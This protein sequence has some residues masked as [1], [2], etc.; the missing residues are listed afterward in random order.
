MHRSLDS[1][2]TLHRDP[3]LELNFAQ[4]FTVCL[5]RARELCPQYPDP[6]LDFR[7]S[8]MSLIWSYI[9]DLTRSDSA[10]IQLVRL[11]A[12]ALLTFGTLFSPQ[13]RSSAAPGTSYH[14][15]ISSATLID[16]TVDALLADLTCFQSHGV[17]WRLRARTFKACIVRILLWI[18]RSNVVVKP[19]D[20]ERL[21]ILMSSCQLWAPLEEQVAI[22]I[23]GSFDVEEQPLTPDDLKAV[24]DFTYSVQFHTLEKDGVGGETFKGIPRSTFIVHGADV[25]INRLNAHFNGRADWRYHLYDLREHSVTCPRSV[26]REEGML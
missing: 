21:G 20:W 16:A 22:S 10:E 26:Y 25:G 19:K 2:I 17:D 9:D 23:T 4:G 12:E 5:Q 11:S 6:E 1:L 13:P 7:Y 3:T 8:L 24:K 15:L 18:W 14:E